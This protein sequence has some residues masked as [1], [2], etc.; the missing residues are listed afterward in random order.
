MVGGSDLEHG[1]E[2]S[3]LTVVEVVSFLRELGL[4]DDLRLASQ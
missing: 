2:T 1:L 3:P 4:A